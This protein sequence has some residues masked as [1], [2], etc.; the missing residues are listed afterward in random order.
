MV[1]WAES[2]CSKR[3]AK[4]L[5][6]KTRGPS[7]PDPDYEKTRIFYGAVGFETLF[8][9]QDLWGPQDAA[10]ILVKRL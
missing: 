2:W 4:W 5:H 3:A 7:T 1:A 8:E 9:T 6:V 10:L